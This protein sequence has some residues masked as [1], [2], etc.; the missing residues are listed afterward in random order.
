MAIIHHPSKFNQTTQ[1]YEPTGEKI[2]T[3]EGRVLRVFR[4][5]YRAMS[6][7]YT[8][9]LFAE[10]LENDG[11]IQRHMVNAGFE[12]DVNGGT[13]EVDATPEVLAAAKIYNDV[14]AAERTARHLMRMA[15][16]KEAERKRPSKGKTLKVVKGRKVPVGTEG[17]CIWLGNGQY[18]SRVGIK[19]SA[20][21]VHWTAASNCEAV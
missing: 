6:D 19:D 16:E 15:E 14:V 9:A 17:V 21:N 12:C 4:E 7:V 13:A 18:G 8:V 10:V 3:Y 20:G 5:D 2:V 11:T 1:T